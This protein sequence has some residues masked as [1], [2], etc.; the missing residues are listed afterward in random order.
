MYSYG[1][2]PSK[3]IGTEINANLSCHEVHIPNKYEVQMNIPVR[4]QG[5]IPKCVSICLTDML[6]WKSREFNKNLELSDDVIYDECKDDGGIEPKKALE[7]V[8]KGSFSRQYD[9]DYST[10]ALVPTAWAAKQC[11]YQFGPIMACIPVKSTSEYFWY[12]KGNLGGQAVLLTGYDDDNFIIRNSWG[13]K[14]NDL[15]YGKLPV[16]DYN[17]IKEAWVLIR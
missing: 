5:L 6:I 12:G 2:I 16:F 4:D 11:I 10:Y 17:Y 15:G 3:L 1:Y 8:T 7:F 9:L 14:W 13:T